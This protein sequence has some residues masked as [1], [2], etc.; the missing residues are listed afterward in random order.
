M[1]I[2]LRD[3]LVNVEVETGALSYAIDGFTVQVAQKGQVIQL[4]IRLAEGL[5]SAGSVSYTD[6]SPVTDVKTNDGDKGNGGS[7]DGKLTNDQLKEH[8]EIDFAD[9]EVPELIDFAKKQLALTIPKNS[10]HET[11]VKKILDRIGSL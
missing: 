9:M 6:A 1:K 11:A 10:K 7:P 4:P 5:V 2:K 8:S 3:K